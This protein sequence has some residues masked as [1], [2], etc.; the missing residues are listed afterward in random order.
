MVSGSKQSTEPALAAS[1]KDEFWNVG[2]S[3]ARAWTEMCCLPG[4]KETEKLLRV[5]V[6]VETGYYSWMEQDACSSHLDL[7]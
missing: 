5:H 6:I 3:S 2:Y 7:G 4:K 1:V